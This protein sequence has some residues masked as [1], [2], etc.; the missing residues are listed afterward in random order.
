[1]E[2]SIWQ[3]QDA[4]GTGYCVLVVYDCL[5]DT[6]YEG[7]RIGLGMTL[8]DSSS[9]L[10]TLSRRLSRVS[11][12]GLAGCFDLSICRPVYWDVPAESARQRTDARSTK[13]RTP[14]GL[15]LHRAW[16]DIK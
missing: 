7:R 16:S 2:A 9:A 8:G 12:G 6:Y 5:A 14:E 13:S 3:D 4:V 10:E 11:S 15:Q 1:V